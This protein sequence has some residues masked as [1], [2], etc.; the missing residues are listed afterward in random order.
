MRP[1][2]RNG[3][4]CRSCGMRGDDHPEG[5]YQVSV[6]DSAAPSGRGYRYLGLFCSIACLTNHLPE[7]SRTEQAIQQRQ[8]RRGP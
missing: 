4:I 6:N 8:E 7:M 5:W 3:V 2:D 1:R